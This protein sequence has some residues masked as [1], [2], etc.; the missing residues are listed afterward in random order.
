MY[1]HVRGAAG[2]E[3]NAGG[4]VNFFR[5]LPAVPL[6]Y[7]T[8]GAGIFVMGIQHRLATVSG[9]PVDGE[10]FRADLGLDVGAGIQVP[11]PHVRVFVEAR[12]TRLMNPWGNRSLGFFPV[13]AGV[14]F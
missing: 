8:A 5:S 11:L 2:E 3:W 12:A 6:L 9:Y 4:Q 10:A 14:A 13:M 7:A 1:G